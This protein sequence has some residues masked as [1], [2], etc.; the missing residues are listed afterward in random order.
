MDAKMI[1]NEGLFIC[2]LGGVISFGGPNLLTRRPTS[3]N[4]K[5]WDFS[6]V[7]MVKFEPKLPNFQQP[8]LHVP[9]QVL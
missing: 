1:L 8:E 3:S 4:K 6:I 5:F 9:Y 2:I 7:L